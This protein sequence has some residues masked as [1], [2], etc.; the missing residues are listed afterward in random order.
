MS[1]I[2]GVSPLLPSE[3]RVTYKNNIVSSLKKTYVA[4][5]NGGNRTLSSESVVGS[6]P[7]R[8]VLTDPDSSILRI[9]LTKVSREVNKIEVVG[10]AQE[11]KVSFDFL[12]PNDG[13]VAEILHTGEKSERAAIVTGTIK[14]LPNGI[15]LIRDAEVPNA[16]AGAGEGVLEDFVPN[17]CG[18][19]LLFTGVALA[20]SVLLPGRIYRFLD[21]GTSKLESIILGTVVAVS[22]IALYWFIRRRR[23]PRTLQVGKSD[24]VDLFATGNTGKPERVSVQ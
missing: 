21:N 2:G 6:D 19:G 9:R 7:I 8:I 13:F 18:I 17:G 15:R 16:I 20:A 1:L 12:D 14:G 4:F 3:V 5:W 10:G 24:I 22:G 11:A 23:I